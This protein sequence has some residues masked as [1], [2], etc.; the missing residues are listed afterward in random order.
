[1]DLGAHDGTKEAPAILGAILLLLG[2]LRDL[3]AAYPLIGF[4][5]MGVI[6]GLAGWAFA[7]EHGTLDQATLRGHLAFILR[8]VLLGGCLGV[9]LWLAW[10]SYTLGPH[11]VGMLAA[12]AIGAFPM[13][14]Y[15]YV[16]RATTVFI[17]KK[18]G[19]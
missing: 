18:V 15:E 4:V 10:E 1:M 11:L 7:V 6:G 9:A 19:R 17:R 16:G 3:V 13:R 8:R 14:A 12:G 2:G 5:S